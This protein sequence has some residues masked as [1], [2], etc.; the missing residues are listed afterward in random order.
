MDT[1][2]IPIGWWLNVTIMSRKEDPEWMV[3]V[4]REGKTV[5][6]TEAASVPPQRPT[7]TAWILYGGTQRSLVIKQINTRLLVIITLN[8]LEF[9]I[10][11]WLKRFGLGI[12]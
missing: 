6:M 1:S 12:V 4:L 7:S 10:I 3:G 2:Q 11:F 9:K 5:W 8:S